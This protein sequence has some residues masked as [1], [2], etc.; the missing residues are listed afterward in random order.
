MIS[1]FDLKEM[2]DKELLSKIDTTLST[3][4]ILKEIYDKDFLV[5]LVR[6]RF[7]YDNHLLWMLVSGHP[8]VMVTWETVSEY[9]SLLE[10]SDAISHFREKLRHKGERVFHSYLT[11]LEMAGYYKERGYEIELEPEISLSKKNP[12]F[13]VERDGFRV[14]FEIRNLF[15][16]EL[17]QMENLDVQI[18]GMF[19]RIDEL[20]VFSIFY[21]P[22]GLQIKHLKGLQRFIKKSFAE[23]NKTQE[24]HFPF[25]L[26]FP[27][28]KNTLAEVEVWGRPKKFDHGYLAGLGATFGMSRGSKN[29]RR[30]ISK[31]ISQLPKGE[32]NIVVVEPGHLFFDIDHVVDALLGD[33]HVVVNLKDRSTHAVRKGDRIFDDR[34]NTRL[35]AVVYY[36]KK[37]QN[38]KFLVRKTV[39]H[40]PFATKPISPDFFEDEGVRQL[41]PIKEESSY[42]LEWI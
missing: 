16:D 38:Q 27:D 10:G 40:N 17:I 2:D 32:A 8:S 31:K 36:K 30:K 33:V 4:Q 3:F 9:L 28:K 29:I 35:S 15:M 26:F 11:E 39:F 6:K 23:A 18:H 37:F 5:D 25:T 20:F 42:R 24:P 13:K 22:L 19:G 34:K 14:Y 21:K 1:I 12:D 41:V 7:H